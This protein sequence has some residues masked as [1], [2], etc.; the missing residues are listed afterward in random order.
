MINLTAL[1]SKTD[2]PIQFRK[3][4]D[5]NASNVVLKRSLRAEIKCT[6]GVLRV[7]VIM[8]WSSWQ[9]ISPKHC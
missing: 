5:S 2:V 7:E 3:S 4:S 1:V 6:V 8:P 9:E